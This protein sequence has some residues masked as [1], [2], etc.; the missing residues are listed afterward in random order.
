MKFIKAIDIN[1]VNPRALQP[2]QWV[3]SSDGSVKGQF[4]GVKASGVIVVAWTTN[5]DKRQQL[6][7]YA[8]A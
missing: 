5:M 3:F 2:G 7:K 8:K 1:T 6:R 4:L